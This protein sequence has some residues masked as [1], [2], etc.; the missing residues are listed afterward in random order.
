MDEQTTD[1]YRLHLMIC[2]GTACVSAG[3]GKRSSCCNDRV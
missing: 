1:K 2:A 3:I